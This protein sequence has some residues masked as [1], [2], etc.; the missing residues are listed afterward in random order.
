[1]HHEVGV[2]MGLA[3]SHWVILSLCVQS[4]QSEINLSHKSITIFSLVSSF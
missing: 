3:G 4:T 1:M 2:G